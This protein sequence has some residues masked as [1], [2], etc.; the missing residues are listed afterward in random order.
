MDRGAITSG[1]SALRKGMVRANAIT[2]SASSFRGTG[3][4]LSSSITRTSILMN[5]S[6]NYR[7][8][9]GQVVLAIVIAVGWWALVAIL[10]TAD[11]VP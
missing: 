1:G 10:F 5:E 2:V 7:K 4:C 9:P 6:D 3:F 11:G 8:T